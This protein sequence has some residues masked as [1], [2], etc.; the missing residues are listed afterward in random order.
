MDIDA[1]DALIGMQV[2]N[3]FNRFYTNNMKA[4]FIYSNFVNFLEGEKN[5]NGALDKSKV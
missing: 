1:G 5:A 2:F 4:W 3:M